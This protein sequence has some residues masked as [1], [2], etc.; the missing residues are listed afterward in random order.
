MNFI[1]PPYLGI[2]AALLFGC[3][4]D[5]DNDDGKNAAIVCNSSSTGTC[6]A[7]SVLTAAQCSLGGGVLVE[8]CPAGALL[9][10]TLDTGTLYIFSQSTF[11]LLMRL[12]ANDPCSAYAD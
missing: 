11:D 10:C 3:A 5:G 9:T 8:A 2:L 7:S 1:R 4:D 12:N 6:F